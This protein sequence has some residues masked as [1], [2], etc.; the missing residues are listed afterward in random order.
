MNK[1]IFGCEKDPDN[2]FERDVKIVFGGD[3]GGLSYDRLVEMFVDFSRVLGY[4]DKTIDRFINLEGID[5]DD[6]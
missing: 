4:G 5:A 1:Y 6:E 3:P 2:Q